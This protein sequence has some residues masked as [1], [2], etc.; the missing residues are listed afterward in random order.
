MQHEGGG[1]NDVA[2]ATRY[3][4]GLAIRGEHQSIKSVSVENF[5]FRIP[6]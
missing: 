1:G 3:H 6:N 4:I 5:N 2:L